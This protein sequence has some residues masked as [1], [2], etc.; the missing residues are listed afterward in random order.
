VSVE[1]E[2][3]VSEPLNLVMQS[4][5]PWLFPLGDSSQTQGVVSFVG[6]TELAMARNA[7]V[8]AHPSQPG[9]EILL[10]AT[11][12]GSSSEAWSGMVSVK[13]G[14]VDAAVDGVSAVPG[15]AGLYTVQVRVPVPM[16]F[17][18][19]VP[20]QLDV[21]NPDGLKF[22]SNSVTIAVEPAN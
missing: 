4:A 14:G 21:I 9:D 13:L 22:T 20:V 6:T 5:S 15:R 7:Q 1:T 3:G 12:L 19:A 8:A 10:W 11:G 2:A 16:A 18:D 17:G